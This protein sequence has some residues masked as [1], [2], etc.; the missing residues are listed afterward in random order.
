MNIYERLR[1][2]CEETN[3]PLREVA[4]AADISPRTLR[5]YLQGKTPVTLPVME[6]IE[7]TTGGY[8]RVEH[9]RS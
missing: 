6:S 9:W 3:R 5:N 2:W 4:D 7:E 1:M 8:V